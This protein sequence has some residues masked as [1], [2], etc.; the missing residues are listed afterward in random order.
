M[1]HPEKATLSGYIGN[2]RLLRLDHEDKKRLRKN[3]KKTNL[4]QRMYASSRKIYIIKLA[5]KNRFLS[6]D[7][8]DKS[9]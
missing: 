4:H 9:C 2:Y 7:N 1:S 8:E 6:L 3:L 5:G